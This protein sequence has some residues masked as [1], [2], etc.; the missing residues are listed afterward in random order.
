MPRG[1]LINSKHLVKWTGV[2]TETRGQLDLEQWLRKVTKN[3][4]Q[5]QAPHQMLDS[6]VLSKSNKSLSQNKAVSLALGV[7]IHTRV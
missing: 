7:R 3:I 2:E 1:H 5:P 4:P 6:T